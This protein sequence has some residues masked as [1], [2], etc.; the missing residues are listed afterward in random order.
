MSINTLSPA[1][2]PAISYTEAACRIDAKLM[3]HVTAGRRVSG[4]DGLELVSKVIDAVNAT[5]AQ[6][7]S[8]AQWLAAALRA[9]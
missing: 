2:D 5:W 8:E 6:G 3:A 9:F 7:I 4:R 1:T